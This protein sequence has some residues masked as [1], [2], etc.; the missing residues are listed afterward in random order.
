[1]LVVLLEGLVADK[2]VQWQ[3]VLRITE[4]R[5]FPVEAVEPFHVLPG[6]TALAGAIVVANVVAQEILMEVPEQIGSGAAGVPVLDREL[7]P[8][9]VNDRH[10]T[11]LRKPAGQIAGEWIETD[12]S[13]SG[14][15]LHGLDFCSIVVDD[16]V[17]ILDADDALLPFGRALQGEVQRMGRTVPPIDRERNGMLRKHLRA[18]H[19]PQHE[20]RVH[21]VLIQQ[22]ALAD[23][24][25][26]RL[27]RVGRVFIGGDLVEGL[28][29]IIVAP[30]LIL[31]APQERNRRLPANRQP[32]AVRSKQRT[33]EGEFELLLIRRQFAAK[34]FN[35]L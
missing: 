31:H 6:Q 3:A 4:R 5:P 33:V 16:V 32:L 20:L 13:P 14:H 18:V 10:P 24:G 25:K 17:G 21:V 34:P 11:G 8:I 26:Q 9:R 29:E 1:M 27:P 28:E 35:E 12:A 15:V 2:D 22:H 30:R 23:M 19:H 7:F